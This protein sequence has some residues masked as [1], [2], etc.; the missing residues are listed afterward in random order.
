ME[1]LE[2]LQSEWTI[3]KRDLGGSGYQVLEQ[4]NFPWCKILQKARK[5][6]IIYGSKEGCE[7]VYME[8]GDERDKMH[9][10]DSLVGYF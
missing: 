8:E 9:V 5:R 2:N 4:P 1:G 10:Y 6:S 3:L 7:C